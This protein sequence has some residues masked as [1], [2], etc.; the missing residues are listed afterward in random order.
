MHGATTAQPPSFI[1][2]LSAAFHIVWLCKYVSTVGG[3]SSCMCRRSDCAD[4][5]TC[6]VTPRLE[7]AVASI[8]RSNQIWHHFTNLK[9]LQWQIWSSVSWEWV[10]K[11]LILCRA[12]AV[13]VL[14]DHIVKKYAAAEVKLYAYL[15]SSFVRAVSFMV[16]TLYPW[17]RAF[18]A[19]WMGGWVGLRSWFRRYRGRENHCPFRKSNPVIQSLAKYFTELSTTNCTGHIPSWDANSHS[20][21]QHTPPLVME[22]Q[23]PLPIS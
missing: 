15:N 22:P 2:K 7:Q 5:Y 11:F 16:R 21:S 20:A 10:L 4:S 23:G 1:V 6:S 9:Y 8:I 3:H 18:C 17:R 19:L 14:E 12:K 13:P